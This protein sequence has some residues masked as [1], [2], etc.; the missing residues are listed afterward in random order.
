METSLLIT[1]KEA[2]T[3][4]H[5]ANPLFIRTTARES[6]ANLR[7]GPA[8]TSDRELESRVEKGGGSRKER[9]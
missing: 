7:G 1:G 2:Q 5:A 6:K 8:H 4:L 3:L 9:D